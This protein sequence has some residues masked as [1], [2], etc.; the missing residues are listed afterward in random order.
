MA[1]FE[2]TRIEN[3]QAH[4]HRMTSR[5]QWTETLRCSQCGKMG[6]V[7]LSQASGPAYHDGDQDVRVE[8]V[9]EG[10]K[11]IQFEYGSNFY[12]SSCDRPVEP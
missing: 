3:Q 12:C 8:S 7:D 10:F 11:A 1:P 9:S 5:D 4:I 2:L 6:S